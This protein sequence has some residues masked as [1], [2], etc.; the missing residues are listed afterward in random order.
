MP[1]LGFIGPRL[2]NAWVTVV[3]LLKDTELRA[4]TRTG[5]LETQAAP[6]RSA[7]HLIPAGL[8]V[9]E[10]GAYSR[11]ASSASGSRW[12]AVEAPCEAA[13]MIVRPAEPGDLG[14]MQ[15]LAS[16]VWPSGWHPGGLGWGMSRQALADSVVVAVDNDGT[17]LIVGIAGRGGDEITHVERDRDDIADAL[18]TWLLEV[19][20]HA[21]ITVWDGAD[22]LTRA[23]KRAGLQPVGREPWS[24]MF[25]DVSAVRDDPRRHV[26]GYDIRPVSA[27]E[28][29]ARVDVHRAAWKPS[30]IPYIDGRRIDPEEESSF[31]AAAYDA[32]RGAWLYDQQL[33]LVAVSN[34]GNGDLAACCIAWFDPATGV[35]EIE[36][37]GV[38]PEHRR[39]G[40]AIALCLEVATLVAERRGTHV[41]IN[42]QPQPG[43]VASTSAYFS[44]GFDLVERATTYATPGRS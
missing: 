21:P 30:S 14:G 40:L 32:V 5:R 2:T 37:L 10:I 38:A 13:A 42:A 39:R 1:G 7:D 41:Y 19:D 17:G 4:V 24:G 8:E 34:E 25:L 29:A 6:I 15:R 23:V 12:R 22:A 36:P 44:A 26:D 35:C 33:D 28:S 20:G 11:F 43:Y 9:Q 27:D 18:V 16:R 31:T 3:N